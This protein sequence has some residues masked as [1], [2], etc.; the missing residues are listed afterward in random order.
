MRFILTLGLSLALSSAAFGADKKM[1][2]KEL[3]KQ[4]KYAKGTLEQKLAEINTLLKDKKLKNNSDTDAMV[5]RLVWEAIM[6]EGSI[7]KSLAKFKKLQD[8]YEKI[9]VPYDFEKS[10][11]VTYLAEA[12]A[13]KGKDIITQ[14]QLLKKL[15]DDDVFSWPGMASLYTGMLAQH[16]ASDP[17]VQKKNAYQKIQYVRKLENDKVISSLVASEFLKG[18]TI[19]YLSSLPEKDRKNKA[20]SLKDEV[21]FFT[22]ST[23][24][25]AYGH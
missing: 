6:K 5:A 16:L 7:E 8:K 1:E 10:L 25:A 3:V 19:Q 12:K 2:I 14:L 22:K 15:E 21:G 20:L 13:A 11:A 17:E 24:E 9:S 18:L 23:V 4:E